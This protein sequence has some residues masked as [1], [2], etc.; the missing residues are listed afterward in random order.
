MKNSKIILPVVLSTVLVACNDES[1]P[2]AVTKPIPTPTPVPT[3][4]TK[5]NPPTPLPTDNGELLDP[6]S[7]GDI[8][9]NGGATRLKKERS[10]ALKASISNRNVKHVILFIGDGTSES[11]ITAARNYAEGAAGYFKGLDVFPFTGAYSTYSLIKGT[12]SIDYVT[13]SAASATAWATGTK[14]YNGAISVDR[15]TKPQQTILELAKSAGFATGN[16]TTTELQDATPAALAAHVTSRKCYAPTQTSKSC[17]KNALEKGG[18]GSITEQ[19]LQTKADVTFGGGGASFK[20]VAKAGTYSGKT[21]YDQAIAMN[22]QVVTDVKSMNTLTEANQNKPVLGLFADGNL[23]VMWSGPKAQVDGNKGAASLCTA[24]PSRSSNTPTLKEMT[25]KAID[26]LK[27]HQK[28]FFLQV[29]SGSI[30]K[31]NHAADACGQIGET[32]ALDE[33]IQVALAFAKQNPDTLI[34]VT[35][36]HA[37]TSQIIPNDADS[38][39]KTVKLLTKDQAE[40]TINYAT[41]KDGSQE[42]TGAQVRTAAYGPHAANISGLLDQTDLFFIIKK[43]FGL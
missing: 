23:P 41:S 34:I 24:N 4:P 19:L 21:L 32:V 37:H 20:D 27:T 6:S 39:G 43:A 15:D 40:M 35:G 33:A 18:A 16:V 13:D 30:D 29:E 38:P 22:Y 31:R 7:R 5:P 10:E 26:L 3:Q 17:P 28:G 9:V 1:K 42:H 25:A 12:K 8:S 2:V 11:E 36:D 14:S